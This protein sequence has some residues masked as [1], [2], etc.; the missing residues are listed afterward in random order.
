[1]AS[2]RKEEIKILQKA[3]GINPVLP[4]GQIERKKFT[5]IYIYIYIYIYMPCHVV[6]FNK[7]FLPPATLAAENL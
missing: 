4:I 7:P 6:H 2:T 3:S 1:M 5:V